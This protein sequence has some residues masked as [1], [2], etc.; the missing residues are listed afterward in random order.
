[1]LGPRAPRRLFLN[2]AAVELADPSLPGRVSSALS[3]TGLDPGRLT[4]EI[5]ESGLLPAGDAANRALAS[6][7]A[8]G[9]ELALDDFGT[10]Y[11]SLSRLT[12]V[13]AGV[14]KADH[15]FARRI[16]EDPGA[17]AVISAVLAIGA[18]LGRTVVAE[19]IEDA[20]VLRALQDLGVS[21]GQGYHLGRPMV[22]EALTAVLAAQPALG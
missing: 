18:N 11:S 3:Q 14:I 22:A 9:C 19:G 20:E 8:L 12:H 21:H 6:L 17:A 5:T 13:P 7:R 1:V 16:L 2:L 10:G 4:L 15:S